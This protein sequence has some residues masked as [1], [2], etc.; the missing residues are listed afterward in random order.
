MPLL[1]QEC[2]GVP[3]IPEGQWLCRRCL[4]SPS[5]GVACALCPNRWESLG[6]YA[7]WRKY[8]KSLIIE[9]EVW[10][11]VWM[12][13]VYPSK[14]QLSFVQILSFVKKLSFVQIL[15]FVEKNWTIE[16]LG[17]LNIAYINNFLYILIFFNFIV[18]LNNI[19]YQLILIV[20]WWWL[21]I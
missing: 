10:N 1:P 18:W 15:S 14:D 16:K 21:S 5:R 12:V 8:L 2:Y 11:L 6:K 9:L 19:D 4:Q 17:F 13:F 7:A 3:Y 20:N